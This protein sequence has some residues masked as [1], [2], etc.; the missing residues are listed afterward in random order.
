M[1]H[2]FTAVQE[3]VEASH[4]A[5][6]ELQEKHVELTKKSDMAMS[7]LRKAKDE[8]NQKM[9]ALDAAKQ[10]CIEARNVFV[11]RR[12]ECLTIEAQVVLLQ[13]LVVG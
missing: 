13:K 9:K 1:E 5:F 7:E 2:L 4:A 8:V 12:V 3:D 11:R 6:E 10:T